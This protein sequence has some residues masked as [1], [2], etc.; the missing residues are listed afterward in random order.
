[1][2]KRVYVYMCE[3]VY[4]CLQVHVRAYARVLV[5]ALHG[6]APFFAQASAAACR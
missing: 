6:H 3:C 4:E 2:N 1:M 5:C